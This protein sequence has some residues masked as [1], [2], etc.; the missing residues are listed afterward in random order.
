MN[1][2]P[3]CHECDTALVD[4]DMAQD[5]DGRQY[6]TGRCPLCDPTRLEFVT[7][8]DS[9]MAWKRIAA[10]LM[11]EMADNYDPRRVTVVA[12]NHARNGRYGEAMAALDEAA[13]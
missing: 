12:Y 6:A 4:N 13:S 10:M 2:T 8:V 1:D 11:A 5:D 7:V 9:A 3:T